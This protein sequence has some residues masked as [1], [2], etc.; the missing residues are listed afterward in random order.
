MQSDISMNSE[1]KKDIGDFPTIA[2]AQFYRWIEW[3]DR[4]KLP[5]ESTTSKDTEVRRPLA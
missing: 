5:D 3:R 1:E 2:R 4:R